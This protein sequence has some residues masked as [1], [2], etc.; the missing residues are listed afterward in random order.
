MKRIIL[1]FAFAVLVSINGFSQSQT[2]VQDIDAAGGGH[3]SG[4]GVVDNNGNR[5]VFVIPQIHLQL[6]D[7]DKSVLK[8]NIEM[9]KKKYLVYAYELAS[10]DDYDTKAYVR[11]NIYED[12]MEFVREKSIY[13]LTKE[14]GRKVLFKESN[15]SYKTFDYKGKLHFFRV[16]LE[17]KNSLIAR[18]VVKYIEAKVAK[19]GYDKAREADFKRK[20]DEFYIS[21]DKSVVKVP[22]RKKEFYSL[23]GNNSNTMKT[24]M[25]ENKLSH[26]KVDDLKKIVTYSNTL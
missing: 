24:Y 18:Q 12:Q 19:S 20:K 13:Y 9:E 16:H 7:V 11:Y 8:G 4:F 23:F 15:F 3:F 5:S 14:A 21:F 26:K 22:S 1:T 25:K 17:G 2:R 6:K 10:V